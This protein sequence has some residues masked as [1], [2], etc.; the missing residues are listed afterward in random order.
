MNTFFQTALMQKLIPPSMQNMMALVQQTRQIKEN[1]SMLSDLLKQ[2]GII[3]EQQAMDIRNMGS[4][5]EQIGQYLIQNGKLPGN[6]Q[7]F[8]NQV[9]QIRD[10]MK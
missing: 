3:S 8:E 10:M 9:N 6:V 1:P 5:Y 7:Q 4:N 2:R